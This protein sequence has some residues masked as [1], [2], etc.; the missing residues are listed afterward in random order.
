[1]E[2]VAS[3][4]VK[5]ALLL[6]L[7]WVRGLIWWNKIYHFTEKR[8]ELEI[9]LFSSSLFCLGS[10][11]LKIKTLK[12]HHHLLPLSRML[13]ASLMGA[14][15]GE[16]TWVGSYILIELQDMPSVSLNTSVWLST[17]DNAITGSDACFS[18]LGKHREECDL[19]CLFVLLF[20]LD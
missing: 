13:W 7:I 8:K 19:L 18:E 16:G 20:Q 10:I 9:G 1:M 6:L 4:S 5:G 12:D 3:L 11:L 14:S 15:L 17:S 2:L